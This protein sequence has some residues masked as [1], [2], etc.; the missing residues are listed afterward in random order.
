MN[1][2]SSDG[3]PSRTATPL[4][5][6]CLAPAL[7]HTY[8]NQYA[9]SE[10]HLDRDQQTP[11]LPY[12][13]EIDNGFDDYNSQT[14]YRQNTGYKYRI[15]NL[16]NLV[17]LG[18]LINKVY[19]NSKPFLNNAFYNFV[20]SYSHTISERP[21]SRNEQSEELPLPLGWSVYFTLR[22]RKYYVDHNTRTTH[23]SHPLEKE[24]LPTG[25]E[26]I[27]SQEYG[28]YYVKLVK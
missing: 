13:Y 21:S 10:Y 8:V 9:G 3:M 19:M 2:G 20:I 22:G 16:I 17:F 15:Y 28:V 25:W 1:S 23:W 14:Q 12:L 27:D 4:Y 18:F 24:G 26:R 7:S 11:Q 6:P 5:Q